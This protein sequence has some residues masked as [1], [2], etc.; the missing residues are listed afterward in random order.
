MEKLDTYYVSPMADVVSIEFEGTCF[1]ASHDGFTSNDGPSRDDD[2]W[3]DKE[4]ELW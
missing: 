3:N 4:L 2:Y 1:G